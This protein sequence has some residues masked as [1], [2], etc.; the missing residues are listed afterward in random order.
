MDGALTDFWG[1]FQPEGDGKP[2]RWHPLV[3][4]CADVASSMEALLRQTLIRRR[5][6]TL[7]GQDDLDDHQV[8]RLC[9]LAAFH[10][11]G[12]FNLGFQA[13][14]H[15]RRPTVETAGHVGEA[16]ALLTGIG[17]SSDRFRE[18]ARIHDIAHWGSESAIFELLLASICHHGRPVSPQRKLLRWVWQKTETLDPFSGIRTLTDRAREWFPQA[19][20]TGGLPLPDKPGFVHAFSGLVM[21]ADWIGSDERTFR[22]SEPDDGE[23][24]PFAREAACSFLRNVGIDPTQSRSSPA[25]APEFSVVF[26]GCVP[27]PAQA[28]VAS[29]PLPG[30]G[31]S[32]TILEAETGAGKTEAA[33]FRFL[34]LYFSGLVDGMYFALPTRTAATQIYDRVT[35]AI[36]RAFSDPTTRPPVVLAV[37]GYL[38]VDGVGGQRS[39]LSRFEVLW[40]DDDTE[41][42]RYRGW[43]AENTK[44]YLAAP[45]AIGTIDQVLLSS[46]QVPHAHLRATTLLRQFLVVDEVHASDAYMARLLDVV[47]RRH[48]S[49]GGH[50]LLMSATLGSVSRSQFLAQSLPTFAE[51]S[52]VPFPAI[53]HRMNDATVQETKAK[54]SKIVQ[55]Q[56][57][58][59]IGNPEAIAEMALDAARQGGKVLVLRNTVRDC[60]ATQQALERLAVERGLEEFLFRCNNTAAPHHARFAREHREALDHAIEA[61]FGKE[62]PAAGQVVVA[63][64]TVQQSLDL[65]ADLLI[66]DLCPVDVLLQRMGRLHRHLRERTAEFDEPRTV[67]LVPPV[68]ELGRLI[69][70]N[71]KA[72]G[73][74]GFGTVY[75]D[76]RILEATWRCLEQKPSWTTPEDNRLLVEFATHPENL[77]AIVDE[78]GEPWAQHAGQ[79]EGAAAADRGLASLNAYSWE[80]PYSEQP[81]PTHLSDEQISTRLGAGDRRVVFPEPVVGPFS[82]P[83]REL[84][85]PSYMAADAAPDEQPTEILLTEAD[86]HFKFDARAFV[87]DRLGLR[88]SRAEDADA[89]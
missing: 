29:L 86:L 14:A 58:P 16:V 83:F 43:A 2:L 3:D 56:T 80:R 63:T 17:A 26:E 24:M 77:G 59:S 57:D 64:Q 65:D 37:P 54:R 10:D 89:D 84:S 76:L 87:Y 67:V 72:S 51:A 23:R 32:L 45:V 18:A 74:H 52:K 15:P 49:A 34:L 1:K 4:H 27:R 85:L 30:S 9:V 69:R 75:P 11:V 55:L 36:Q 62:R 47:L 82:I 60:V 22:Y 13:K 41:R 33:L 68:R 7:A 50:A 39:V 48:L 42:Y 71:G 21:L 79:M 31:P 8:A 25:S 78:L 53:F 70:K 66:T 12:K 44:R 5:L 88:P 28:D 19:F 46:L 38:H 61:A 40:N 6:A 20:A 81:F 35:N 73:G